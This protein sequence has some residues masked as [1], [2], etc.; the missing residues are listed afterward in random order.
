MTSKDLSQMFDKLASDLGVPVKKVTV[1][2]GS[3]ATKKVTFLM[4]LRPQERQEP[5]PMPESQL[6][7]TSLEIPEEES[8]TP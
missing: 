7:E 8:Q 2:E 4:G 5:Q 1:P 3:R 6:P